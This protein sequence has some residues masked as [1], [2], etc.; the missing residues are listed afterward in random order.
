MIMTLPRTGV[1]RPGFRRARNPSRTPRNMLR[2]P[3]TFDLKVK[4]K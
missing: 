2:M 4:I 3:K 1:G